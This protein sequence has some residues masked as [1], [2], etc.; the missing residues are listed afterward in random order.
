MLV[1]PTVVWTVFAPNLAQ[2]LKGKNWSRFILDESL[3]LVELRLTDVAGDGLVPQSGSNFDWHKSVM[4][5]RLHVTRCPDAFNS[6]QQGDVT[7]YVTQKPMQPQ[8]LRRFGNV[9][10]IH[11][12]NHL[13]ICPKIMNQQQTC[14]TQ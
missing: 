9:T 2:R 5:Q 11:C 14:C 12:N 3:P 6:M 1:C 4:V 8:T 7:H 10:S 13:F